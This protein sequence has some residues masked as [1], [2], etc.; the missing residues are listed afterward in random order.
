MV[1][2]E[3]KQE[4]RGRANNKYHGNKILNKE[5]YQTVHLPLLAERFRK[6]MISTHVTE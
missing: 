1:E 3:T 4:T 2:G 5:A 6:H